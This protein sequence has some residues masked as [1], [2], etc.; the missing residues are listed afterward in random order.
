MIK[1]FKFKFHKKIITI[2]KQLSLPT[3]NSLNDFKCLHSLF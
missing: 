2:I 1:H 3:Y